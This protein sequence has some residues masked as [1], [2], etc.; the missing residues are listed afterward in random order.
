[1][2]MCEKEYRYCCEDCEWSGKRS[3]LTFGYTQTPNR[4]YYYPACPLC[5][6]EV[7]HKEVNDENSDRF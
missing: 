2:G 5:G 3:E 6:S 4:N 7:I 1:M